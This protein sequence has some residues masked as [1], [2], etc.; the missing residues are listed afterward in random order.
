ML[1]NLTVTDFTIIIFSLFAILLI[2]IKAG[3]RITSFSD[4]SK[5]YRTYNVGILGISLS[6]AVAGGG[7]LLI[8]FNSIQ[9]VGI[10]YAAASLGYIIDCLIT[11]KYV[12]PRID[13]RFKHSLSICEMLKH[14]YDK[15]VEKL[16][17]IIAIIFD[18]GIVSFGLTASGL[19]IHNVFNLPKIAG[20]CIAVS[21]SIFYSFVGGIRAVTVLDVIKCTLLVISIPILANFIT[22][23]AG[24]VLHVLENTDPS[25]LAI[26]SHP[27]FTQY[28]LLFLFFAVPVHTL[29]PVVMQRILLMNNNDVAKK[30][31]YIYILF[32]V[33]LLWMVASIALAALIAYPGLSFSKVI[34]HSLP[35]ILRSI[36]LVTVF[37]LYLSKTDDHLNSAALIITRSIF[38][39]PDNSP[40]ALKHMRY[41][42]S[43][44]GIIAAIIAYLAPPLPKTIVGVLTLWNITAAIPLLAGLFNIQLEQKSYRKYLTLTISCFALYFYLPLYTASLCI[45][46]LAVV[47]FSLLYLKEKRST[48]TAAFI[49]FAS[50]LAGETK[51]KCKKVAS[52]LISINRHSLE[53][54]Y[55]AFSIFFCSLYTFPFFMWDL[56][57]QNISQILI[58]RIIV[59]LLCL[60]LLFKPLWPRICRKYFTLYWYF[61]LIIT[62]PFSTLFIL[63][64]EHWSI[65]AL[66]NAI[67]SIFLLALL[68]SW[69]S[70]IILLSVGSLTVLACYYFF[71]SHD[72]F[73]SNIYLNY[74]AIYSYFFA[75]LIVLIFTRRRQNLATRELHLAKLLGGTVA[76]ELKTYLLTIRNYTL[77]SHSK[78]INNTLNKAFSFINTLLTNIQ[79]PRK[80][81]KSIKLSI[82]DC[83]EYS[84][85]SYPIAE[86]QKNIINLNMDNDFYFSG[87]K[88]MIAHV[89]FN[90]INNSLYYAPSRKDLI[91]DITSSNDSNYNY[92]IF[93][94]NGPGMSPKLIARIF[95]KFYTE[96]KKG[97]G[98]G[99]SFCKLSM[100]LIGG[101]IICD[102]I[103]GSYTEF[104][105]QFPKF[106]S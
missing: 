83:L 18:L 80:T 5:S 59:I 92:L 24:G 15:D 44:L 9:K 93:R 89:I 31:L 2:G 63:M 13:N 34:T 3:A 98:L 88:E 43:I 56:D 23:D 52:N 26:L 94:D 76:H 39:T 99:L 28:L 47:I 102:S 30:S 57:K 36:T 48:I 73:A 75:I 60:I 72:I 85:N 21:F 84:I 71:I 55:L 38:K 95:D 61:T 45:I 22:L 81:L 49:N 106:T 37:T 35:P 1:D 40:H 64:S 62:L 103:E 17:A 66:I 32:R 20:I 105:L 25:K 69:L 70:F 6:L 78:Q 100:Q 91:I 86:N 27:D 101:D 74:I 82:K 11:A 29:Q 12:I 77:G 4:Y 79:G 19:L 16:S 33:A 14:F 53:P 67:L 87:D 54:D 7:V 10:I 50:Y 8:V 51:L 46:I 96:G 58:L 97:S 41:S 65:T 90:L 68:T 104:V 42:I